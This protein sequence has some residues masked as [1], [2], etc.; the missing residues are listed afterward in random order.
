M[1]SK[2]DDATDISEINVVPLVD[3]ILVVLI[4]FMVTAPMFMRPVISVQLPKAGTGDKAIPTKLNITL[5]ADGR[6]NLNGKFVDEK[7]LRDV[8]TQEH[9]QNADLQAV[10]AADKTVPH[11]RVVAILDVIKSLGVKK[12]AISIDEAK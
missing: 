9:S 5:T 12:F 10:I 2:I 7:T 1:S 3:I 8:T 6:L 11:G 4:I